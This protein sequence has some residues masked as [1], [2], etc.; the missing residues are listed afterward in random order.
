MPGVEQILQK[1]IKAHGG[2]RLNAIKTFSYDIIID[3]KQ[4]LAKIFIDLPDK[5]RF[6]M[7]EKKD[8]DIIIIRN[9]SFYVKSN[10][11]KPLDKISGLRYRM[12]WYIFNS[13]IIFDMLY[14]KE[15]GIA[16]EYCGIEEVNGEPA[17]KLKETTRD[18][19]VSLLYIS[20]K[21]NLELKREYIL[22]ISDIFK[23]SDEEI[24]AYD[25]KETISVKVFYYDMK[26]MNGI[27]LPTRLGFEYM[28]T[29]VPSISVMNVKFNQKL[30]D[31]LFNP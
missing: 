23:S 4:N 8:S 16:Y 10:D 15:L 5:I 24:K 27:L 21:S 1:I 3:D 11:S 14:S 28:G 9:D 30:S 13:S 26:V 22:D 18:S 29:S 20:T 19:S 17:Y 12:F 7:F 25:I 6:E 2:D 31:Q